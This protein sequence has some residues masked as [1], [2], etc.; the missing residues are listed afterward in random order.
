MWIR[1]SPVSRREQRNETKERRVERSVC[2]TQH[3]APSGRMRDE[4]QKEK[5]EMCELVFGVKNRRLDAP[6]KNTHNVNPDGKKERIL[7]E[8]TELTVTKTHP[9]C[10]LW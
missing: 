2:Q 5:I 1:V 8:L 7:T 4:L 9:I 6:W 3:D 10:G